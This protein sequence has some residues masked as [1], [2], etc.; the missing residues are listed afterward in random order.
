MSDS[1]EISWEVDD[2]YVGPSRPQYLTLDATDFEGCESVDEAM[3]YVYEDLQE[4]LARLGCVFD[5]G[6][7]RAWLAKVVGS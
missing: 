3:Q 4:A 2:G 1:L 6:E 7:V 5:E